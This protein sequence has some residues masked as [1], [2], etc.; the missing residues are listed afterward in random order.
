MWSLVWILAGKLTLYIHNPFLLVSIETY[1]HRGNTPGCSPGSGWIRKPG[2]H[3]LAWMTHKNITDKT[4]NTNGFLFLFLW[5]NFGT[6]RMIKVVVKFHQ[7]CVCG[8]G[9]ESKYIY[10]GAT[11]TTPPPRRSPSTPMFKNGF[12]RL[13]Y[14]MGWWRW[15]EN[16]IE[17]VCVVSEKL[18]VFVEWRTDGQTD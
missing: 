4:V 16:F 15:W 6:S 12:N 13:W 1:K 10:W 9:E 11:D 17:I 14:I 8:F 7:N 5:T 3:W 2:N 18:Q